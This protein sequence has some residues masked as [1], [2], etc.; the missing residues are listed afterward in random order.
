VLATF[1]RKLFRCNRNVSTIKRD[2]G[3]TSRQ[4]NLIGGY[5]LNLFGR[6]GNVDILLSG[7][8]VVVN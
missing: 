2:P 3:T 8:F 5:D 4:R 6:G 1:L 7:R